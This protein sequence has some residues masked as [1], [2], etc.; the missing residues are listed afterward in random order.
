MECGHPLE[1][2][3]KRQLYID[4]TKISHIVNRVW[5]DGNVLMGE[6]ET[7]A[8]RAGKDMM[9]LI[10]QGSQPA[11]SMRGLTAGTRQEGN[12]SKV[13]SPLLISSYDWVIFPSHYGSYIKTDDVKDRVFTPTVESAELNDKEKSEIKILNEGVLTPLNA[14]ELLEYITDASENANTLSE[15]FEF[16]LNDSEK[17]Y[18][19]GILTF[20]R[21]SEEL[22]VF[23]ESTIQKEID[24]FILGL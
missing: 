4:Q 16:D 9:G 1:D 2:D 14:S 19:N 6:V 23:L 24:N 18:K 10:K 17:S 11:F 13:L 20:K 15:S 12:Y 7:A 8:T 3:K 22:K 21:D 5:W